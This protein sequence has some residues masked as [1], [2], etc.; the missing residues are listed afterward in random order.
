[1]P[2]ELT[3]GGR[4]SPRFI[5]EISSELDT[6]EDKKASVISEYSNIYIFSSG[7]FTVC[8]S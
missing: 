7:V 4:Y 3:E 5:D 2:D 1:V 8:K 6:L